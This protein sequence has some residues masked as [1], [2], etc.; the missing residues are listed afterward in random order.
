M[1]RPLV[2]VAAGDMANDWRG[3]PVAVLGLAD[4]SLPQQLVTVT[5]GGTPDPSVN[6][7]A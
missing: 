1:R 2:R 5:A 7:G 3:G 4:L 6:A